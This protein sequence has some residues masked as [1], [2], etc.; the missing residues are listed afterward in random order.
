[1]RAITTLFIFLILSCNNNSAPETPS[2]VQKEKDREAIDKSY[3][4]TDF[5]GCFWMITGK[6]TAVAWLA[7]TENTITGKLKLTAAIYTK[8]APIS[9][10]ELI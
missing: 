2:E 10:S 8:K 5:N 9:K 3:S 6:D 4:V 1:M 7:Q